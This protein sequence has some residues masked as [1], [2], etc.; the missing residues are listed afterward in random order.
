VTVGALAEALCGDD[1]PADPEGALHTHLSRLRAIVGNDL[2]TKPPGYS[3]N[4]S[5]DRLDTGRFE[6]ILGLLGRRRPQRRFDCW[7]KPSPNGVGRP[8]SGSRMWR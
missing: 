3:L 7:T 5:E 4:V 2:V 1:Q 8:S 6:R